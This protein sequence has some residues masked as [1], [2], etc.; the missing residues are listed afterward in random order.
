MKMIGKKIT[1]RTI[2]INLDN[3]G[4]IAFNLFFRIE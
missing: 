3:T 1:Y 4:I 2:Y